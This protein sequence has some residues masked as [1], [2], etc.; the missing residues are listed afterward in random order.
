MTDSDRLIAA[1]ARSLVER[2]RSG[3]ISPH[4]LLDSLEA[5]IAAVNPTVNALPTLCFDRAR[6]RADALLAKPAEQRGMLA[7]LPMPIKDSANVSGVRTTYGSPIFADHVPEGSDLLVQRLEASGAVVF[8]KSNTPEFEAGGHTFNPV[9]GTTCNPWDT[10]RSP[11]GST[12][13]GAAA[14]ASGM[15]WLAQGSDFGGSLRTPAAFCGVVGLRP[16]PGRVAQG[17]YASAFQTLSVSGPMARS[18]DDLALALD[19]M[20]GLSNQDPMSFESP[21]QRFSS[22]TRLPEAPHKV[23]YS[24]DLGLTPV[25]PDIA[26]ICRQAMEKLARE[27]T[28][29]EPARPDL[30]GAR[31]CFLTLRGAHFAATRGPLLK[32]HRDQLKPEVVWNIEQGMALTAGDIGAAENV[33]TRLCAIMA[34]FEQDYD[35]LITPGAIVP[36]FP[37]NQRHVAQCNGVEFETYIDWLAITFA[38]SLTGRPALVLPCGRTPTGLPVGLQLVGPHRGEAL[39]LK[40]AAWIEAVLD[41]GFDWPVTPT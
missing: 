36:A 23:G 4:D 33:R 41:V 30:A 14:L 3:E 12:G 11:G 7:G 25:D 39:L 37:I 17:P 2:L 27:G 6:E 34:A 38:I 28:I 13:G 26:V 35:L 40:W 16:S 19:A 22:A 29:V 5:R 31:D 20:S 1:S 8:A 18:V 10:G 9:F 32:D 15:A 21:L 24:A